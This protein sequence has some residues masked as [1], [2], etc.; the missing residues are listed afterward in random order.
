[1][2]GA[3]VRPRQWRRY[4]MKPVA[5]DYHRPETVSEAVALLSELGEEAAVLSGGMAVGPMVNLRMVRPR[6]VIGVSRIAALKTISLKDNLVVT[7]ARVVQA[8]PKTSDLLARQ[9][10]LLAVA[11]PWGG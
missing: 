2:A 3:A 4:A 7:G 8:D 6:V 10:P 5:F 11:L 9:L 1:M